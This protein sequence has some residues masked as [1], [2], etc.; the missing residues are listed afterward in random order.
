VSEPVEDFPSIWSALRTV[1]F[2]QG[3]VDAAGIRTRFVESGS[4]DAPAVVMLHGT[5]GHWE[6]FARNLGPYGGHF[7]TIAFDMVGNGFTD[8]PEYDYEIPQY[9]EHALATMDALGVGRANLLGTSLGSWVAAA[10][11]LR[12]PERVDRLV[13]MSTAGL[14]G[15]AENMAR[16]RATRTKAVEDP[17]WDSIKAMF[18]HLIADE[19]NRL[20][21]LVSLRQAIYRQPG[22]SATMRHTLVLQDAEIRRRNL[23]T[24]DQWRSITAPTLTIASGLD[25]SEY[26][27][28]SRQVAALMPNA[29]VFEMPNVKHW[30]HFEDADLFNAVSLTFLLRARVD[31][32]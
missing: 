10:L 7:R 25:V 23:I 31:R 20:P 24:E 13:F 3:Y 30:P 8:H 12:H 19:R 18:D 22:M 32:A 28:T 6:T 11:A 17:N 5:G 15:T 29:E 9:V 4:P 14:V 27:N 2:R 16:I 26:T 1:S 21:D